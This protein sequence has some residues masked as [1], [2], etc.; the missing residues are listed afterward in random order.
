MRLKAVYS[1]ETKKYYYFLVH[2][3]DKKVVGTFYVRKDV[4]L[5]DHVSVTLIT[6]NHVEWEDLLN[7][8]VERSREGSKGRQKLV[9][10]AKQYLEG[11]FDE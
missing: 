6:P 10:V 4:P 5:P 11:G 1:G 3:E 2:E 8:M 7:V 9:D